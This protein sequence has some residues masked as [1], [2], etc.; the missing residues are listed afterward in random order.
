MKE[1]FDILEEYGRIDFS[2]RKAALAT[3]VR[4]E[5]SSYRQPGARM[6]ITD[7]GNLTG[8]ISGGC[9][10]GDALRKALMVMARG[11]PMMVS[12]DTTDENDAKLGI[13]LGCNGIIHI[14]IEPIDPVNRENPVELLRAVS[15]KRQ[16]SV[17]ITLCSLQDKFEYQPGTCIAFSENG[18]LSG[19]L[20]PGIDP[21]GVNSLVNEAMERKMSL[22]GSTGMNG[23]ELNVFADLI[24]PVVSLVIAGAGNDVIPLVKLARL[25]AW[26]ITLL[27]GRASYATCR[28]FPEVQ[29]ILVTDAEQALSEV[30][31]DDRTVFV[32]MTHN[33]NYDLALLKKL[34]TIPIPYIGVLGPK[35]KLHR[36]FAEIAAGKNG[37]NES[38]FNNVYGPVGLDI[39]AETAEEIA[40][41][42]VAEIKAILS[43]KPGKSLRNKTDSI[44]SRSGE[45]MPGI[46]TQVELQSLHNG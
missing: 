43:G 31:P 45:E 1:I 39:G 20:P 19:T 38:R 10:E 7:D 44:H 22:I 17:L 25:M 8:A 40:V 6:L 33:Y 16:L 3:V 13:G 14:L 41:S 36:M 15:S 34:V 32:L 37:K 28:R 42:V 27:D 46:K 30:S 5:G 35:K 29:Q 24:L 18:R 2:E 11:K 23:R 21:A 9:L 26:K 12:Y 4:V